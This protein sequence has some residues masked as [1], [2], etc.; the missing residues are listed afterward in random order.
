M[1][2]II[3]AI[4]RKCMIFSAVAVILFAFSFSAFAV[5]VPG[6]VDG[7]GKISTSDLVLLAQYLA[8][9]NVEANGDVNVDGNIDTRD[10]VLLAQYLAG[11]DVEVCTHIMNTENG[12]CEVCGKQMFDPDYGD[13]EFDINDLP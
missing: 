13:N 6:D 4:F 5:S 2:K 12:K 1:I 8:G 7:N 3:P 10:L 9:W 11:W